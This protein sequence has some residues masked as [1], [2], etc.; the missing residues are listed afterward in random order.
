MKRGSDSFAPLELLE[1]D[2]TSW[3]V[4]SDQGVENLWRSLRAQLY[5][6]GHSMR[7][8]QR[9]LASHGYVIDVTRLL[10]GALEL[11]VRH[12]LDI[13][14]VIGLHPV[15]LFQIALPA[16]NRPSPL[17]RRAGRLLRAGT[18]RPEGPVLAG[19]EDLSR[20]EALERR[21]DALQRQVDALRRC[22]R[23]TR[24]VTPDPL[25]ERRP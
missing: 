25:P 7:E 16:P 12:V 11:K 19:A 3:E 18:P 10:R 24:T 8:V 13:C 2:P 20:L 1:F 4:P 22:L 5:V 14:R 23:R 17:L 6:S 21:L 9:V 15:E